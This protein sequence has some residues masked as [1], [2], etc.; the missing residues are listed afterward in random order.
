M[1]T[2]CLLP[3]RDTQPSVSGPLSG[4]RRRPIEAR[5]PAVRKPGPGEQTAW[6]VDHM[7]DAP[8]VGTLAEA[9]EVARNW[10]EWKRPAGTPM[11]V[12]RMVL[13]TVRRPSPVRPGCDVAEFDVPADLL[14]TFTTR[15]DRTGMDPSRLVSALILAHCLN[16]QPDN[17]GDGMVRNLAAWEASR[18]RKVCSWLEAE[19]AEA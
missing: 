15:C 3:S 11:A 19:T 1:Q 8:K 9:A 18:K 6:T 17:F 4:F 5:S 16:R 14:A 10:N 12:P 7:P 13:A 2:T